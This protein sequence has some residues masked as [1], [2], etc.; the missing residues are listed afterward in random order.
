MLKSRLTFTLIVLKL[1][2][3]KLFGTSGIRRLADRDLV[4]LALQ[5]GLA[6]GTVYKNVIIGR[7]TRTSGSVL[8][9]AVTAGLLA[10]GARCSDAGVVPTPTVAFVTREFDAGIML[11]ASHNPPQYNGLKLLNPDGSAFSS[12]QQGQVENLINGTSSISVQWEKMQAGEVYSTATEKHIARIKQDFPGGIKLKIVVDSGCGAAYFIT[13]LLLSQLGCEVTALNGYPNGIFPHDVEP[14]EAN[15]GDLMQMVRETGADLGIAHDGDADRMMAV[16]ELGRFISGDKMLAILARAA[17]TKNIVTTIDASMSIEDRRFRVRRTRVGDPY[18]SEELKKG[19]G[20][21]GEPSGAWVFP[22]I[23]LCPDGIYAAAK[24]ASIASRQKLSALVD[25]IPSYPVKR[26]NV[27][28]TADAMERIKQGLLKLNPVSVDTIDGLK[29]NFKNGWL[30]V[31]PSGT[32]PKI[33]VTAEAD[34]ENAV[35][36]LY[37]NGAKIIEKSV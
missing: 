6:T 19:G 23:S 31:R 28:G 35:R 21:G 24:I 26:G 37:E 4:Q 20:F 29:L 8:R 13:A 27:P 22:Q 11:T 12:E 7:D 1:G 18:V 30:L 14:I 10:A 32:E 34:T 15:L 17:G 3:M 25:S 2:G 16:D 9:H 5:V 33:R 36:E